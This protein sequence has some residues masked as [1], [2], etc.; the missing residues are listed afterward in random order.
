MTEDVKKIKSAI[1][2]EIVNFLTIMG[3]SAVDLSG[4]KGYVSGLRKAASIVDE[5]IEK[6]EDDNWIHSRG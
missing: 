5:I 6:S 1:D 4:W 2:N 3:G